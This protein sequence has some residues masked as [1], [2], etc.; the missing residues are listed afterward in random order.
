MIKNLSGYKTYIVCVAYLAYAAF[1]YFS[2]NLD[3]NAAM[4][5]AQDAFIGIT[6]R[7]GIA[8]NAAKIDSKMDSQP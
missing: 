6:L 4:K 3:A 7:S 8:S 5:V 1:G 2:G